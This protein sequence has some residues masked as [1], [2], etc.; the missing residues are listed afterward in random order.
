MGSKILILG[1]KSVYWLQ[2]VAILYYKSGNYVV[3]NKERNFRTFRETREE[4]EGIG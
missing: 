1:G 2:K 3:H 4:C